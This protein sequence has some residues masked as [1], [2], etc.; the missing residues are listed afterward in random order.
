MKSRIGMRLWRASLLSVLAVSLVGC[1]TE[2]PTVSN[3]SAAP[4]AGA[5]DANRLAPVCN[6][7]FTGWLYV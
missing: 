6:R 3:S 4:T 5:V 2:L 7:Q 1:R